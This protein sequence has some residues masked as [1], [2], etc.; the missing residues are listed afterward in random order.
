MTH[1]SIGEIRKTGLAYIPED[2]M[3]DGCAETMS[4]AE[5]LVVSNI[6]SFANQLKVINTKNTAFS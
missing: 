6:D 4:V 1:D 2:R 3:Y 5:N